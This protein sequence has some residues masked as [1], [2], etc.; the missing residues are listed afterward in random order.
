M[1]TIVY[2]TKKKYLE[3]I[4]WYK[5]FAS[6]RSLENIPYDE[7]WA[8]LFSI[9]RN[10]KKFKEM[11]NKLRRLIQLNREIRIY[12]R[13]NQ[14]FR[15]FTATPADEI[16]VVILGQDPYFN[17]EYNSGSFIPQATGLSFSVPS[18]MAIPSSL[19]Q[20]YTNLVKYKHLKKKP[21]TGNLWFWAMQGCLMLNTA[22]TVEDGK[23][24]SHSSMWE[25]MTNQMIRYI[26]DTMD[27]IIFVLWGGDAY[28]KI[29]LINLDRH[30]LII[31]SHP[32][33]L[34][35]NRP[36]KTFPSFANNDHFG[37]INQL[38]KTMN[39]GQILWN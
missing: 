33:G 4:N 34:S 2:L 9:I 8:V 14:V 32:S 30:H 26:S 12:P 27:G 36:F 6:G 28:A 20:I 23:K 10:D 1:S 29:D 15:A 17:C 37:Q 13:P 22:L 11:D 39:R 5:F 25:W 19:D 16:K 21:S 7:S 24:K 3:E 31:S 18:D 35:A 38:L